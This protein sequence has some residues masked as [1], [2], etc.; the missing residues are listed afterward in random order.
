MH[1][2]VEQTSRKPLAARLTDT[3][4]VTFK[5]ILTRAIRIL[6]PLRP[7]PPPPPSSSPI[8]YLPIHTR[9]ADSGG[10]ESGTDRIERRTLGIGAEFTWSARDMTH[11]CHLGI[12]RPCARYHDTRGAIR[13]WRQRIIAGSSSLLCRAISNMLEPSEERQH[14]PF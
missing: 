8:L 2:N 7:P 9:G 14:A 4:D 5:M 12:A 1:R 10:K 11:T 6:A 13:S 3:R